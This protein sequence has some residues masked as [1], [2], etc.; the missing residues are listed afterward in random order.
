MIYYTDSTL[1]AFLAIFFVIYV[2]RSEFLSPLHAFAK[3][4]QMYV[5]T[6]ILQIKD[7][8]KIAKDTDGKSNGELFNAVYDNLLVC[9]SCVKILSQVGKAILK[10]AQFI[11]SNVTN[12][13]KIGDSKF[14][15]FMNIYSKS[16][17]YICDAYDKIK[18]QEQVKALADFLE[19]L[20][21]IQDKELE[22]LLTRR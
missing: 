19:Y 4:M 7:L 2:L 14:N 12:I 11:A 1:A 8:D 5:K 22:K 15:Q 20:F 6:T 10:A 3:G 17:N 13:K 18:N 9:S 16:S 21:L